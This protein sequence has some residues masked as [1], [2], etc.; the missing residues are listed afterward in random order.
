M[1]VYIYLIKH[2]CIFDFF[3]VSRRRKSS[4][5][6]KLNLYSGRLDTGEPITMQS[7]CL[8]PR[9]LGFTVEYIPVPS[10]CN[11]IK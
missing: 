3:I 5:F 8:K 11:G 1:Y 6:K 9:D 2:I 7:H 4:I 10:K